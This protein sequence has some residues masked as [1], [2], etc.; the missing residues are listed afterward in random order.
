MRIRVTFLAF[1]CLTALAQ[2]GRIAGPV[3]GY[4]FDRFAHALRPVTGIPGASIIGSPVDLPFPVS[5]MWVS[6][7][8]DSAVAADA[9]GVVHFFGLDTG[10]A[11]ERDFSGPPIALQAV[12]FSP[13]GSAAALFSRGRATI[14][15]GLPDKPAVAWTVPLDED[16]ARPA[17]LPALHPASTA[18][19][20][21]G[22]YLLR[23]SG[24]TVVLYGAK[25][26]RQPLTEGI[27]VAFA[28]QGY[29]A[30]VVDPSAGII[31]F[32]DVV[33]GSGKRILA[34]E[35]PAIAPP[36]GIAFSPD[37]QK[38]FLAI[39]S[40]RNVIS[41]DWTT[42]RQQAISC[43]FSPQTVTRMGSLLRLN[44]FGAD[45]LWLLDA[46]AAEPRILFVPAI[47]D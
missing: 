5:A 13:S 22:S 46:A 35:D 27:G 45:P 20:E 1:S 19:S 3:S 34:A 43:Q 30:A 15:T 32:E 33:A 8:Q 42:G 26:E 28:P 17:R 25:G 24:G 2:Q 10:A 31:A 47:K 41:I 23:A 18:L 14:V 37:G 4:V 40:A 38:L 44:E 21:D 39:A 7:R 6:P 12:V 16:F 29:R 9:Q 11:A 36:A